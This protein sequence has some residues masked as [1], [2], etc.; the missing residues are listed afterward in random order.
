MKEK[1]GM[2]SPRM[3]SEHFEKGQGKLGHEHKMKYGSE[4]G[5][6]HSLDK[7]TEGLSNYAKKNKMKYE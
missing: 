6:P 1:K 2:K 5:N 4:M 3:P 7:M